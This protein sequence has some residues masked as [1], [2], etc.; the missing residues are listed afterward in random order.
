MCHTMGAHA[1]SRYFHNMRQDL[2]PTAVSLPRLSAED[3]V[4]SR[5][6]RRTSGTFTHPWPAPPLSGP[7]E[8]FRW[9]FLQ[10][11]PL[12]PLKRSR[13][14]WIPTVG[15]GRDAWSTVRSDLRVQWLG[16]A[17]FLVEISET[18]ILV[19]PVFGAAGPG[20]FRA[21]PP[22]VLPDALP[23]IDIILLSHGHYDHLD[24]RSLRAVRK[25]NPEVV[26]LVP[27]GQK[28]S[29][30]GPREPVVELSWF[31]SVALRGV[32]CTLTP[33]Q[34]WHLRTPWD[35]NRALWGGWMMRGAPRSDGHRPSVYHSGDTG[36]FDGF[37]VIRAI[38]GAPDV[39]IL[40]LGAY[41]PRWFMGGQ[42]MPPEDSLQ[43]FT[44]LEARHFVGMHWGTFDLSDEPIDHGPR[45]LLPL[46]LDARAIP[47]E[48]VHVLSH[49]GV[50]GVSHDGRLDDAVGRHPAGAPTR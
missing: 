50:L 35:R 38:L 9:K 24:R 43:A 27:S 3:G 5:S 44:D 23:A 32:E 34:H 36:W 25:R 12:G 7:A 1:P 47:P 17:S 45:D 20:V 10:K 21:A 15:S 18:T 31:E 8:V 6:P 33:A 2:V 19:D 29:I 46:Q 14:P 30:P 41:E 22:P 13:T 16:H 11:N 42:H 37:R 39:A 4:F 26:V 48:R 40:P 49:G 28:K